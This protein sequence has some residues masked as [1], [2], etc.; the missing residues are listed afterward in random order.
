MWV[1][2]EKTNKASASKEWLC[3]EFYCSILSVVER[4]KKKKEEIKKKKENEQAIWINAVLFY[5]CTGFPFSLKYQ[6]N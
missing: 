2:S 4:K 6:Y 1:V 5:I 3:S